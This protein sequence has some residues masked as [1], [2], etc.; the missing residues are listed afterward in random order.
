[1]KNVLVFQGLEICFGFGT[2]HF[3]NSAGQEQIP[4]P[5]EEVSYKCRELFQFYLSVANFDDFPV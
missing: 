2:Q 3:L 5:L 1:M 4:A